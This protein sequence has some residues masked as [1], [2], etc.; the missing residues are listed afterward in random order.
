VLGACSVTHAGYIPD[1]AAIDAEVRRLMAAGDVKGM[2][3]AIIDDAR[4]V[5]VAAFGQRNVERELPLGTD[6]IMYGASFTKKI[7]LAAGL[8][9]VAFGEGPGKAWF[10]GGHNDW[11]GNM[12]ICQEA[13]RRCIVLLANSLRAELIYPELVEFVLPRTGMPWWWEYN[14]E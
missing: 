8:G 12:A 11:T 13:R 5:H 2:A 1:V 7:A 3:L 9:L 6:T 10:K 14:P 4:V